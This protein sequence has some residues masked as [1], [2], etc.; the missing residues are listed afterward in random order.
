MDPQATIPGARPDWD[1]AQDEDE[2][3]EDIEGFIVEDDGNTQTA[4][5]PA[6]FSM[7]THQDLAHHF[8]IVCQY[9]V[10]LAIVKERKRK[11]VAK[12]LT[13]GQHQTRCLL[14]FPLKV[15]QTSTSPF[16]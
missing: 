2:E 13:E 6:A 5:L 10:H 9:L 8:K 11:K 4:N 15:I 12:Q 16:L 3:E 1:D 14:H 7:N